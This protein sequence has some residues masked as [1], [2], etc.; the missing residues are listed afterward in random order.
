MLTICFPRHISGFCNVWYPFILYPSHRNFNTRYNNSSLKR[1]LTRYPSFWGLTQLHCIP[2]LCR[3]ETE[4]WYHQQVLNS[5]IWTFW[6]LNYTITLS[7]NV[8]KQIVTASNTIKMDASSTRLLK[9]LL[10]AR[11]LMADNLLRTANQYSATA[12]S[13]TQRVAVFTA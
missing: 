11:N 8:R 9:R 10:L 6:P 5:E 7:R 2:C 13:Y 3:Y 1:I 12:N 4:W